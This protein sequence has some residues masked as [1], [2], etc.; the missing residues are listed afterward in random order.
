MAEEG[1]VSWIGHASF[2]LRAG[3]TDVF[4]DPF[5]LSPAITG[6]AGIVLITHAH[7]DHCSVSDIDKVRGSGTRIVAAPGCLDGKEFKGLEIARPGFSKSIDGVKVEAVPAY[8]TNPARLSYHPRK[9]DWV[10]YVVEIDGMRI[11]HAGD[12]DFV[13]EMKSLHD[14]D[15]ALLPMGGTYTMDVEEAIAA[16]NA[17]EAKRT[18]PMH[19]K[20]LLGR[21]GS[22]YAEKKF[23]NAVRGSELMHEIQEPTYAFKQ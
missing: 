22:A 1:A 13:E 8:N 6:K 14:I 17:I 19:Y 4:I 10:G 3:S 2:I 20:N 21:E 7:F 5:N 11:Y 23:L 16:A 18:A 15:L 9:N 12:T